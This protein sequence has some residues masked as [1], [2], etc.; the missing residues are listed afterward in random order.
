MS[1]IIREY[2]D[3]IR[4]VDK[5]ELIIDNV[6][7]AK[8]IIKRRQRIQRIHRDFSDKKY[9]KENIGYESE[10]LRSNFRQFVQDEMAFRGLTCKCIRCREVRS[11]VLDVDS[12]KI[13]CENFVGKW[14]KR[15]V[16]RMY[17]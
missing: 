2:G 15:M 16:L 14:W 10:N 7:Y 3:L 13:I 8:S 1:G 17:R 12:T 9:T 5:C 4:R 11:Q 6:C